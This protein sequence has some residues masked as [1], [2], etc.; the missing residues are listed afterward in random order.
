MKKILGTLFFVSGLSA[1]SFAQ[2]R[3][4]YVEY[5]LPN[6]LHV[7]LHEDHDNPLTVVSVMYHVGSQN[8]KP[9]RTGFA[10]FFEHLLFEGSVNIDRGEYSK[11]VEKNG[12][13][14]NANTTP[15]RTYYF[16]ILPSNQTELGLWLEAERMLH[17]KVDSTGIETQRNVV[18]EER[19]MRFDNQPYGTFIE[20]AFENLYAGTQYGWSVIGSMEHLSQA[21]EDDYVNF[22]QT[23]YV[24]SN[25]VLSI[26]GDIDIKKTKEWI[27]KYYGSIPSGQ[28]IN[29]YR[30]FLRLDDKRFK[31]MYGVDK[32][33]FDQKDF[34]ASKNAEAKKIIAKYSAMPTAINRPG[35]NDDKLT[36]SIEKTI[37]DNVDLP[38]VFLVYKLPNENHPDAYALQLMNSVLAGSE[39][40]RIYKQLVEKKQLST[41]A[42]SFPY[43][44]ENAGMNIIASINA[45]GK[46]DT[47]VIAAIEEEITKMQNE[48]IS[49]EEL[50]KVKNQIEKQFIERIGDISNIAEI[51]AQSYMY[52]G[53]TELVNNELAKYMKVTKEDIQRVAKEYLTKDNRV[54]LK[55]LPKQD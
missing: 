3:I 19:R 8:E 29:L 37:Y 7:I 36:K 55:Y 31:E 26:A 2:E 35:K 34:F 54:I 10:H 43:L 28:A 20:Q 42:F 38:G 9:N 1:V 12:G 41:A 11:L 47:E 14:L 30:N 21:S 6:G 24:P 4:K 32:S 13:A 45:K 46:T 15:D 18:K 16:E 33:I 25:A 17:A 51:L 53:S 40:S 27:N 5:D 22:Y 50:E 49:D 39:S 44:K 52:Q 48:L 23:Y